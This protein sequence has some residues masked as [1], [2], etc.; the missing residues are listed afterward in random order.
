MPAS[1]GVHLHDRVGRP[2]V[3]AHQDTRVA[4]DH[5][6]AV[7]DRDVTMR[8]LVLVGE[9]VGKPLVVLPRLTVVGDDPSLAVASPNEDRARAFCTTRTSVSSKG[10]AVGQT[11]SASSGC[12]SGAPESSRASCSTSA[13]VVVVLVVALP[14]IALSASTLLVDTSAEPPA[15]SD[16]VTG[17][18]ETSF[19]HPVSPA[20]AS[21]ARALAM[22]NDR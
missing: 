14:P 19:P 5:D 22:E 4:D 12:S 1:E 6:D 21:A 2:S 9:L 17:V 11:T 7:G 10:G 16:A 15:L 18:A 20:V 8:V 13:S 3:G